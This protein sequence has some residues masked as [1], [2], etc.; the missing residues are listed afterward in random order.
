[1]EIHNT[2]QLPVVSFAAG[3][4]AT[5]ADTTL[6]MWLAVGSAFVDLGIFESSN[7]EARAKSINKVVW[8][9]V[10]WLRSERKN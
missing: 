2:V 10:Q 3:R 4:L 6:A 1:M 9:I 7:P 8:R 5:P